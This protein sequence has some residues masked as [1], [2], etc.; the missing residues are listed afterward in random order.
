M[1]LLILFAAQDPLEGEV[2]DA[3]ARIA[4][5]R[6]LE[7]RAPV[8]VSREP[9]PESV[10]EALLGYYSPADD[11]LVV[12]EGAE[13][14]YREG[15]LLHE[16]A[17]A[18]QDQRFGLESLHAA[19]GSD[20][21][22]ARDALIEGDAVLTMIEAMG[23]RGARA[24]AMLEPRWDRSPERT[25]L[26]SAGARFVNTLREQGG[27]DA[28]NAAYADPP[29]TS[30]EILHPER[31]LRGVSGR[32]AALEPG[33][34]VAGEYGVLDWLLGR[35]V[36][37]DTA[38]AAADGWA[39]D[40]RTG[41][42]WRM[43][44][45]DAS[46]ATEF[47]DAARST[48]REGVFV[49]EENA[50]VRSTEDG[51]EAVLRAEIEVCVFTA[52]SPEGFE[53]MLEPDALR[54]DLSGWI[55]LDGATREPVSVGEFLDRVADARIVAVGETHDSVLHHR[56]Q[57]AVIRALHG[58][59]GRTG[60]GM[61][62][63]ERRFQDVLDKWQSAEIE[64]ERMLRET[65]YEQRWSFDWESLYRP[66]AEFCRVNGIPVAGL[67]APRELVQGVSR[68]GW[69][70]LTEVEREALGRID[71][72]V[73]EHREHW[74]GEF[75]RMHGTAPDPAVEE[76][77]YRAMCVWDDYM[78]ASAAEFLARRRLDRIVIVAGSGHTDFGFGIP[79]RA[80]GRTGGER[81]VIHVE[82]TLDAA[83]QTEEGI[84]DFILVPR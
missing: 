2:A 34:E 1:L 45:A 27:W 20:A 10:D 48:F 32:D 21:A 4:A 5:A 72:D 55:V 46:E 25:F 82:P 47:F 80:A 17:H 63:F 39:G 16:L 13:G 84:A 81:V 83:E 49:D 68:R 23:D 50:V 24:R 56:A 7:F 64:E 11:R 36:T 60:V 6:G 76:R 62:M 28:V 58:L 75:A 9:R 19:A 66:I 59:G 37:P 43:R 69:D 51:T 42:T 40:A 31:F 71:F 35:G 78:G 14:N 30:S 12:Y 65:E 8:R 57:L 77:M 22:R 74:H 79:D 41:G 15:V 61:E 38:V 18:L 29:R 54:T 67:N 70:A 52:G 53:A 44:W 73:P 33:A 3:C 26:Y